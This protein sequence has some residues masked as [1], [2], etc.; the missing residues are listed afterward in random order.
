M[1]GKQESGLGVKGPEGEINEKKQNDRAA[2]TALPFERLGNK[3]NE[4]C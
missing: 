1:I 4:S 2:V 3:H